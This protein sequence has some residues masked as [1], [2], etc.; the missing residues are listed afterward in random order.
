MSASYSPPSVLTRLSSGSI[1]VIVS[2]TNRT[3]GL[4]KSL[5]GRRTASERLPP[6][7]HVELRVAED[8]GVALVDQSHVRV[9]A[10]LVGEDRRQLEAAEP[11]PEYDYPFRH[12]GDPSVSNRSAAWASD[13]PR[14][15]G[16]NRRG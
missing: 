7:H 9:L 3:P 8:E 1:A 11:R 12:T 5:Y 6:E 4:A 10:E 14:P 16:A 15:H 2:R 13:I